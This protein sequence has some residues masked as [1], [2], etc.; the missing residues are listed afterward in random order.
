MPRQ[1]NLFYSIWKNLCCLIIQD[2]VMSVF[3]ITFIIF[4]T[5]LPKL[6]IK[7]K[8]EKYK[9]NKIIYNSSNQKMLCL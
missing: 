2:L 3:K 5:Y 8:P 1:I 6:Y 7:N 9:E 4:F